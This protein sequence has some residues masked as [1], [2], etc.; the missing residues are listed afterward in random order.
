MLQQ[1]NIQFLVILDASHPRGL[2]KACVQVVNNLLFV[3]LLQNVK[4][5]PFNI[6]CIDQA[7]KQKIQFGSSEIFW[8]LIFPP[9]FSTLLNI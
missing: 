4:K 7:L 8:L 9:N 3:A 6:V 2:S 1:C 5:Y